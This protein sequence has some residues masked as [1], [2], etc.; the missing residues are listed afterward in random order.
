MLVGLNVLLYG[1]IHLKRYQF[2][3]AILVAILLNVVISLSAGW[4]G[5]MVI[6]AFVFVYLGFEFRSS[7][8]P[9]A[10]KRAFRGAVVGLIVMVLVYPL[11]NDYRRKLNRTDSVSAAFENRAELDTNLVGEGSTVVEIF[12]RVSGISTYYASLEVA[13]NESLGLSA[14]WDGETGRLMKR[15]V[16]GG[17]TNQV[18]AGF[19]SSQFATLFLIGGSVALY[20]G[21]FLF[22]IFT[23]GASWLMAR[24]IFR[25]YTSF[26]SVLPLLALSWVSMMLGGGNLNLKIKEL[27]VVCCLVVAIE[28]LVFFRKVPLPHDVTE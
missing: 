20:V 13:K 28:R 23:R 18:I 17:R 25:Y 11:V 21:S 6:Q 24:F 7:L 8:G 26:Q 19:G 12:R 3:L 27:F 4:K 15:A 1:A 16:F 9:T 5:E 10:R 22:G 14:L 2:A